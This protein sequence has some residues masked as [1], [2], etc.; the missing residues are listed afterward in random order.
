MGMLPGRSVGAG[1]TKP[2]DLSQDLKS[3]AVAA[4]LCC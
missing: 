2:D 3:G 4:A 1:Q